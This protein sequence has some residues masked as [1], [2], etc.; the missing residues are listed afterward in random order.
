MITDTL[1]AWIIH[2]YWSGDTSA[3]VV[4]FTQEYGLINCLYKGG[5]TPKKQALLQ[6][7]SSLWLTMDIRG[8]AYFVRQLEIAAVPLQLVGQPLFAGLYMNELLYHA[9]QQRDPNQL[10]YE[11]YGQA[12]AALM[13]TSDR[14][15]IEIILR[16]FEWAILTACGF[17]MS[18]T[19]DARSALPI[20]ENCFYRFVAGEGFILAG[21][22]VSGAH[23]AAIAAGQLEDAA[24]LSA[25]KQIMRRAI[26]HAL[27][28]KE[29]KTRA[30][31][32]WG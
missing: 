15:T 20:D 4:F 5:R 19:H 8:D 13:A 14:F 26:H 28:G 21:E 27:D 1:Q 24:V 12:L 22:G 16:R 18:L 29:I 9:L 3:R 2:K 7:F 31:Y 30:L 25:A 11:A 10:L 6:A 23:I 32:Q 17:Q